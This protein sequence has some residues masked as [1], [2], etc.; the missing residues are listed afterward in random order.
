MDWWKRLHAEPARLRKAL[1]AKN[2]RQIAACYARLG[3]GL[4]ALDSLRRPPAAA[5]ETAPR[6]P[7][8]PLY[9]RLAD[10]ATEMGVHPKTLDRW[11]E[12][13]APDVLFKR[14]RMTL[15]IRARFDEWKAHAHRQTRRR[16]GDVARHARAIVG[17]LCLWHLSV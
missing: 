13:E 11:L 5:I 14:P 8:V 2:T 9:L 17:A 1:S 7:R 16:V 4:R 3:A 10:G 15:L 6:G 12:D